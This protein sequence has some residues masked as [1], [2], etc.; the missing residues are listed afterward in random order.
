ME[1]LDIEARRSP[2]S[3]SNFSDLLSSVGFGGES[4][5]FEK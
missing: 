2:A 3:I 1:K 4:E 5:P